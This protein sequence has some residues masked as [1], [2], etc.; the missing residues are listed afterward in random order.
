MDLSG[1]GTPCAV[2]G[3]TVT[4]ANLLDD[5]WKML[6]LQKK[7]GCQPK[8]V[9][10]GAAG[11]AGGTPVP[12]PSSPPATQPTASTGADATKKDTTSYTPIKMKPS[13]P[14]KTRRGPI[15]RLPDGEYKIVFRPRWPVNLTD[16]GMAQLLHAVCT[17]QKIPGPVAAENDHLRINPESNAFTIS[18]PD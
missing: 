10:Q 8:T 18:R 12:P 5:S 15:P 3:T 11:E 9:N 4:A 16:F 7:Y 2:E 17:A 6:S 14:P 13:P 1:P